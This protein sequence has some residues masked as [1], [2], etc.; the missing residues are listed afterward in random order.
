M[1]QV[2]AEQVIDATGVDGRLRFVNPP[3]SS[4]KML[5]ARP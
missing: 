1:L 2:S 3:L 5:P 4:E